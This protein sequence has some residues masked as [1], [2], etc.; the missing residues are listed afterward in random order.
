MKD[1]HRGLKKKSLKSWNRTSKRKRKL[2]PNQNWK[3]MSIFKEIL[4]SVSIHLGWTDKS[5]KKNG[6]IADI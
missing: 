1:L 5:V 2:F 6:N 4:L 3:I